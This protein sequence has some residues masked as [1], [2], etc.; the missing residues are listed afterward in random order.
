VLQA[1]IGSGARNP[2]ERPKPKMADA[3]ADW[4]IGGA[5]SISAALMGIPRAGESMPH[6]SAHLST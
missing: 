6:P 2:L 5:G 4:T 3:K 1:P